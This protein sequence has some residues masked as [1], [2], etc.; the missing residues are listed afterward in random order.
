MRKVSANTLNRFPPT[1]ASSSTSCKSPTWISS[2][3]YRQPLRLSNAVP[4]ATRARSSPRPRRFT[5]TC[6]CSTRTSVRRIVLKPVFPFPR[7]ARVTSWTKFSR[8]RRK[9]KSCCSLPLCAGRKVN[10]AM[11]SSASPAKVLFACAWMA[12]CLSWA[13]RTSASSLI[14]RNFTTS[15]PLWTGW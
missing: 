8:S 4:A 14:K 1:R 11:C 9:P 7:K 10:S 2:K 12:R 15:K 3:V 13:T 6:G 5:I